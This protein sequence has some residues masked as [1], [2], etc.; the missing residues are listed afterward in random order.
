MRDPVLITEQNTLLA[1]RRRRVVGN[2]GSHGKYEAS[3]LN[4]KRPVDRN[5]TL[6]SNCGKKIHVSWV[7]IYNLI[8]AHV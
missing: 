8:R 1:N 7:N 2:T 4:R 3:S 6:S 5:I